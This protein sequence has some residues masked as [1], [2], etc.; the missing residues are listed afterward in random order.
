MYPKGCKFNNRKI[1]K[2][3][4]IPLFLVVVC[5]CFMRCDLCH[6]Y[7]AQSTKGLLSL[8]I[9]CFFNRVLI[10]GVYFPI[11]LS[12]CL[13]LP[14]SLSLS[15]SLPSSLS[16]SLSFS[17]S[18]FPPLFTSHNYCLYLLAFYI[19]QSMRPALTKL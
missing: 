3:V 2:M 12:L 1:G 19:F 14:S 17:L 8:R 5:C 18:Y 6:L 15:L 10:T 9:L 11:S 7:S 16:L 4:S 13:S